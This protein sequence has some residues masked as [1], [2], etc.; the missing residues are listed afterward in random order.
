[1]GQI[2]CAYSQAK[3]TQAK[4]FD[5]SSLVAR[6]YSAMGK[7]WMWG[8]PVPT[9][10]NE[11]YDDEFELLW[12][13]RYDQIGQSLG[14]AGEIKL[15]A[16]PGDLQFLCTDKATTRHNKI[17]HVTM[18]ADKK[19]IVHARGTKSGVRTDDI[20][21]YSGKVC[22]IARYNPEG[23]L[24]PGMKG[25]RVKAMQKALNQNGAD[26]NGDGE[27]GPKTLAALKA[28][29]Q[30]K[31]LAVDGL[32]GAETMRALT[33]QRPDGAEEG[34]GTVWVTGDTVNVRTGPGT[35]YAI[36]KIAKKG[37]RYEAADLADW[38]PIALNGSVFYLSRKYVRGDE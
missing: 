20:A 34:S 26:L 12:P 29:Q 16:E 15:G 35:G 37:E 27:F 38:V 6:A 24:R 31:G 2:G 23:P 11:V 18:V 8:G 21:L 5:C 25:N 33:G 4:I 10:M 22:A 36:A 3:R 7:L 1:M 17:T 9:S 19:T 32:A 28:F 13:D 14:G 30:A